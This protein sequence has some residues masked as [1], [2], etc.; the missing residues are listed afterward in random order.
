MSHTTTLK[1]VAIKDVAAMRN[2]VA[3]LRAKGI[4]CELRENVKPR[5]YYQNQH[6]VCPYVLA[7]PN[8]PYDV[9][10]DKQPDGSYAPV[11]DE[12][13]GHIA[14]QIG[15]GASCPMPNTPEGRA[16]HA[17]GQFFQAYAKHATINAATA[18]G[19]MVES[20]TVDNKGNVQLV[21]SGM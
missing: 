10:F 2:A 5:M 21:L 18:Q 19:Y 8:C 17:L 4:N 6:G 13:A 15:A 14:G 11:F 1:T 12:W 9:G 7:L 3:E 16:Q 20:A